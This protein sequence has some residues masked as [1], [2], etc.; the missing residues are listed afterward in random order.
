MGHEV[1]QR[2]NSCSPERGTFFIR[3]SFSARMRAIAAFAASMLVALAIVAA[4]PSAQA[5]HCGEQGYEVCQLVETAGNVK[6]WLVYCVKQKFVG[7]SWR[8]LP[9]PMP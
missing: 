9:N 4:V 1:A 2:G 6:D 7:D 3:G 8:C 5:S